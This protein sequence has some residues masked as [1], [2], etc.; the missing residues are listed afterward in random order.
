[1]KIDRKCKSKLHQKCIKIKAWGGQG[2]LFLGFWWVFGK[3]VVL[4][5]S[6]GRFG[7]WR[8]LD[9]SYNPG[10]TTK[11]WFWQFC[12][13]YVLLSDNAWHWLVSADFGVHWILKGSKSEHFLN[14]STYNEKN[15]VQAGGTKTYYL[16][17]YI[18]SQNKKPEIVGKSF[19]HYTCCN[20]RYE[21]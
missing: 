7:F 18:W 3:L 2:L 10:W 13:F 14:K 21:I 19:S 16:L 12:W 15:D 5:F 8:D 1:M 17:I 11:L 20:L 4:M 9:P 6:R